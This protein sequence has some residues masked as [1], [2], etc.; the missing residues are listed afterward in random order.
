MSPQSNSSR[1]ALEAAGLARRTRG[2]SARARQSV[3]SPIKEMALLADTVPGVVSLGWG[4]PSFETPQHIREAARGRLLDDTAIGKYPHIR[5]LPELRNAIAARMRR[6]WNVQINPDEEIL[7]T[8]GAQQALFTALLAIVD[9]G[10]EVIIP[11]P[12]F[13]SYIDQTILAGGTPIF[14]ELVEEEGWKLD[15]NRIASVVTPRTKAIILNFPVNPTGTVF[16]ATDLEAVVHLA[17][18]RGMYIVTDETYNFLLYDG[19]DSP[20]LL[21]IPELRDQLIACYSFSKEYAMTGW[22]VGYLIAEAGLI[23][24]ILKIHDA[25]VIT[26]PR[27][28]QQAALAAITG[29]QECV[30]Y[31]REELHRRRHMACARLDALAE[32]FEYHRP[33]GAYYVFPRIKIP[34]TDPMQFALRLLR[35]AKVVTVPGTAFGPA[36]HSHLRMCFAVPPGDIEESF[37]RIEAF[38]RHLL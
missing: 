21:N 32:M 37:D 15:V 7:I 17:L 34:N 20:T 26:A 2:I 25:S 27:V 8:V 38:R 16:S 28:S 12:C 5:G 3:V 30:T 13:S 22:R 24:E 36:G 18:E 10:D 1:S 33:T 9:P 4:L 19:L 31:F 23:H 14:V 6:Q 29:P 11:S 35:E